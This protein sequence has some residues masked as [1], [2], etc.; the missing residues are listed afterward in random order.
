MRRDTWVPPYRGFCKKRKM[1]NKT[2]HM[3]LLA[4]PL[5]LGMLSLLSFVLYYYSANHPPYGC[6]LTCKRC[7]ERAEV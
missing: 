6:D 1:K 3:V 7:G 5:A 4:M 2:F